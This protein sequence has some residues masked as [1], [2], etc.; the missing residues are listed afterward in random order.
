MHTTN[1]HEAMSATGVKVDAGHFVCRD[2]F[3]MTQKNVEEY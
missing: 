1:H 3:G 2:L